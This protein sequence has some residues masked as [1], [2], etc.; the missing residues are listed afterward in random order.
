M[1]KIIRV[2]GRL[3]RIS[4]SESDDAYNKYIYIE[5]DNIRY[6]NVLVPVYIDDVFRDCLN[7]EVTLSMGTMKSGKGDSVV[8]SFLCEGRLERAKEITVRVAIAQTIVAYGNPLVLFI[9]GIVAFLVAAVVTMIVK[10]G[11]SPGDSPMP[12]V[13]APALYFY[14]A[15]LSSAAPLQARRYL[16]KIRNALN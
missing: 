7:K 9:G 8:M 1:S 16:N 12:F 3:N 15:L 6:D 10:G 11:Q 5:I 13:L 14:V 2:S 4:S